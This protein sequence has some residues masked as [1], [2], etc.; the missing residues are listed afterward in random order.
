VVLLKSQDLFV[1]RAVDEI[2]AVL[3]VEWGLL[4]MERRQSDETT[5]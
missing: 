2:G 5:G 4:L 3:N 1:V